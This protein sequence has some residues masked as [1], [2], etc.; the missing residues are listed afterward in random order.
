VTNVILNIK[1]VKNENGI[2]LNQSHYVEKLLSH[3]GFENNKISPTP[4]DATV[5]LRKNK[6]SGR[7][8]LKYSQIIKSLI[9]LAGAT[10]P[11]LSLAVS[12]LS[13]F[14]S[15]PEDDYWE[16]LEK[17]LRYL[18]GTTLYGIHCSGYPFVLKVYSDSN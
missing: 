8:Q 16:A 14:T 7:H 1:L 6:G 17:V 9:H 3:V 12:K 5:K 2:T 4:Y 15:N 10:R 11:N 18:R 13:R